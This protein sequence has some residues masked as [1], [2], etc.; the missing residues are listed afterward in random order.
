VG[1]VYNNARIALSERSWELMSLRV[2][3]LSRNE[4]FKILAG[5][6][7]AQILLA[8]P[9]GWLLGYG[10]AIFLVKMMA[11]ETVDFPVVIQKPSF[12]YASL[13]VLVSALLST[14]IIKRRLDQSDLVMALKV[15]E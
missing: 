6:M 15:R 9:L 7:L 4:V 12:A 8:L 14:W 2:L 11:N 3:G 5:E 1:V 13:I 10:F